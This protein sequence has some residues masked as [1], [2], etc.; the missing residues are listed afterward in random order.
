ML[1]PRCRT[2]STKILPYLLRLFEKSVGEVLS[3]VCCHPM[4]GLSVCSHRLFSTHVYMPAG[5][6][7]LPLSLPAANLHVL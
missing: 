2:S 3:S 7:S 5:L 1:V 6:S 4:V